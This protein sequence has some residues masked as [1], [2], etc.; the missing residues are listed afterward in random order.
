MRNPSRVI[1]AVLFAIA[2]IFSSA[3]F[4]FFYR[5]NFS[6]HYPVKV[7]AAADLAAGRIPFWNFAAGGGQP[8]A[9]N[10]NTLTFYPDNVLYLIFSPLIAF[11]LH[12]LLHIVAAFFA[13]RALARRMGAAPTAAAAAAAIYV[14]SGAAVSSFA[15]YNFI[16]AAALIPLT[17]LAWERFGSSPGPRSALELG[18]ACGLMALGTEPVTILGTGAIMLILAAGRFSRRASLFAA[19]AGAIALVIAAPLLLAWSEI[20]SEV[21]RGAHTYSAETVLAASLRPERLFEMLAGPFLGLTTDYGP[22]GYDTSGRAGGWPPFFPSLLIGA[23]ALPAFAARGGLTARI[24]IA[25]AV[26]LF[27]ALG[28][29]NPIVAGTVERFDFLRAFRYPEKLALPL[30][31]LVVLLVALF[32][33][34]ELSRMQQR[35]AIA[36]VFLFLIVAAAALAGALVPAA[37]VPR[38]IA[39]ASLGAAT[40]IALR[41][42]SPRRRWAV[43]T[44]LTFL[45]LSYWAVRAIPI[46]FAEPYTTTPALLKGIESPIWRAEDQRALELPEPTARSRYRLAAALLD[47]L[48]AAASGASYTFDRSPDGMYSLLSRIVSE[49]MAAAEP[50]LKALYLRLHGTRTALSRNEMS[51][52]GLS[53]IGSASVMGNQLHAY[54]VAEPLPMVHPVRSLIPASSIQEAVSV[55]ESGRFD[56]A[57]AAIGPRGRELPSGPISVEGVELAPQCVTIDVRA[58]RDGLLLINQSYFRAWTAE[59]ASRRLETV[60]LN[61]DRLGIIIPAGTESITLRFGQRQALVALAWGS[62]LLLLLAAAG[63]AIRSRYATAAPA[64]YSEPKTTTTSGSP[65]SA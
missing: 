16:T 53:H 62:S 17:L 46:D 18:A 30:T 4:F 44:F 65:D 57:V 9:G 47:P 10:P 2:M 41:I 22:T 12:F 13:M 35:L 29:F 25:A 19:L 21:E 3:R 63:S 33:G 32:L 37:L 59:S 8:L 15:L 52:E 34:R 20:A 40:L 31:V 51:D 26:L 27:L 38:T 6:T 43:V 11:N 1:L 24:R 5:D 7:V 56:P 49:R 61:I 54:R 28:R 64:R 55:I 42:T 36:G 14:L 39:G 23:I 58:P 45:P 50:P 60:P 48:H